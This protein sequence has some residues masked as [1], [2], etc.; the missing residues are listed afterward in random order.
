MKDPNI[1]IMDVATT[2]LH[3]WLESEI[4]MKLPQGFKMP[5]ACNSNS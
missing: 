1:D 2:Y 3:G 4:Y 5:R